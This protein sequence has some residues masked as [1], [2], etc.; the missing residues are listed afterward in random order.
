MIHTAKTIV[1]APT[2][3]PVTLNQA[4]AHLRVTGNDDNDY[5]ESL[6]Q[7]ARE[8]TED[9]TGRAIITQTW[10]AFYSDWPSDDFFKLPLPKLQSVTHVKYKGTTGTQTT[11]ASAEY[12]VDTDREP[13]RVSLDYN[14]SWPSATLYPNLPI[15]I[16][17]ICGYGATAEDVPAALKQAMLL[18]INHF[19]QARSPIQYGGTVA[20]VPWTYKQLLYNYRVYL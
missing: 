3:E 18:L 14:E 4:K 11:W 13:G 6:I 8:V 2:I 17:F 10:K 1:T 5:I 7:M 20:D 9:L 16:Q 12:I 19:Y 15:E